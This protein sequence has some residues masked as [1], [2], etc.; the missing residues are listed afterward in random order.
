MTSYAWALH[1]PD[2]RRLWGGVT[3]G[4]MQTLFGASTA[5]TAVA[6]LYIVC[7]LTMGDNPGVDLTEVN[8][9]F[10]TIIWPASMWAYITLSVIRD[11][12]SP[13]FL[14]LNVFAVAL[15]SMGV[16]FIVAPL[17]DTW[18]NLSAAMLV[19]QHVF[20]DQIVWLILFIQ[21]LQDRSNP[22]ADALI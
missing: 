4:P 22:D 3:W 8:L 14:F 19:F 20:M 9:A 11:T 13:F 1:Q 17:G 10:G 7:A 6:F 5:M 2:T 21:N 12:M 18:L 15:G 16:L